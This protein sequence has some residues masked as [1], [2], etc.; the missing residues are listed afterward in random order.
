[1]PIGPKRLPFFDHIVEL[2]Q[3]LL[4]VVSVILV[5]STILYFDLF[6]NAIWGWLTAPIIDMIPEGRFVILG[7]FEAFTFRFKLSLFASIVL[8]SPVTIWQTLAFFLPALKS[9]ERRYVVPTFFVAI[10]LFAVG[11]AFAYTV[12]MEPAFEFMLAQG[13]VLVDALPDANRYL[14]GIGLLMIGFGLAFEIPIVVF[15]AIGFGLIPYRKLRASWRYV[16][17]GLAIIA[18]VATPDWSPITM[19]LLGGALAV[20]Y[21]GSMLLARIAFAKRIREQEKEAREL[22]RLTG[23]EVPG[24][25]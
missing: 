20:L 2:R 25:A 1:M 17:T 22:A 23:E 12:I 15:Y 9:K 16:Y 5:G 24:N 6:Y 21:E 10:L 8:T 18:A 13:G 11:V 19:G 14:T 4:I 3:R 7:P